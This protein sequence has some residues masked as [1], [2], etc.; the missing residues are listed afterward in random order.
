MKGIVAEKQGAPWIITDTLKVPEPSADQIL[1]K[2]IFTAVN[3]VDRFMAN[4]GILVQSWP[5]IAGVDAAGV[6]VK[7]GEK[8]AS[9]FK[10]GDEV[11]GC[12]RLGTEGYSTMEEYF[13]MDADVTILKPKNLPLVEAATIGVGSET[14]ALA[15]WTGLE[16]PVPDPKNLPAP[17]DEWVIVQG[18]SSS[19]GKFSIQLSKL[20]GY[21]VIASCSPSSIEVVKTQGADATF[22]YKQSIE[23]QIKDALTTTG[24][25]VFG[26]VDAAASG[27]GFAKQLFRALP[28]KGKRFTT[29]NDWSGITDFE[30]GHSYITEL[31]P[32]GRPD[33]PELNKTLSRYISVIKE[34]FESGKLIPNPYQLIGTGG[35]EDALRALEHQQ[36]GAGGNK[37]VVVKIQDP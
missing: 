3:P 19:V 6:V 7:V 4:S 27:D 9:G 25:N 30:G 17:K 21:R 12:T 20:C 1:V 15:V 36:K 29:T 2:S 8:A 5:L 33:H 34:L 32:V 35:F 22:D 23:E 10:V 14:A 28:E 26:V 16:I 13:L 31:G 24:G 18:G 11:C 37:K